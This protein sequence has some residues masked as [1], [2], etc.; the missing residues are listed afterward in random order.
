MSKRI[1]DLSNTV[2]TAQVIGQIIGVT[3][4][5][6]RQLAQEG[7]IPKLK[8]GSYD[9]VPTINAYIR[10]IKIGNEAE[11]NSDKASLDKEKFLHERAKRQKAELI[12]G[13][14]RGDLH[15]AKIVEEIMTD[16][17]SNFRSKL[18]SIPSKTAP[19]LLGIDDIPEL[20]E[21]LEEKIAEALTELSDYDPVKFR[22]EKYIEEAEEIEQ[23]RKVIPKDK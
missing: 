17:L 5:R 10:S 13:E 18:L 23:D 21:I 11:D 9:L 20:Q 2:V 16:M 19:I 8:N 4:R 3:D 6:V 12:L 7:V 14:M 15:D 1:G 22:S